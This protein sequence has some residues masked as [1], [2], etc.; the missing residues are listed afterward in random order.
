MVQ[1]IASLN[2]LPVAIWHYR[3]ETT[4]SHRTQ[5]IHDLL[6][7]AGHWL[8]NSICAVIRQARHLNRC[9]FWSR[10]NSECTGRITKRREIIR[11]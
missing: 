6:D 7:Y 3:S 8:G 10:C 4:D 9:G 5:H 2:E 11:K 1:R